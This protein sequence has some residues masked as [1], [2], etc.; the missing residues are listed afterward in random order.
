[1][2]RRTLAV[3]ES[4][5][6]TLAASYKNMDGELSPE[7]QSAF[8][9]SLE[10]AGGGGGGGPPG[11]GGGP[12]GPGGPGGGGA[13]GGPGPG[14]QGGQLQDF[15][16]VDV[17]ADPRWSGM[18]NGRGMDMRNDNKRRDNGMWNFGLRFL[19]INYQL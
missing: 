11:I 8:M 7:A 6:Q 9:N 16:I 14:G 4:I 2:Q 1:M 17:L 5:R 12:G 18:K 15:N 3:Q 19:H 10:I 13:G